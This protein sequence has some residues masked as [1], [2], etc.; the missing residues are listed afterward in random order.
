MTK[1]RVLERLQTLGD[2][3][4]DNYDSLTVLRARKLDELIES[5]FETVCR[6]KNKA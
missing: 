4:D 3:I 5:C 1:Q 2:V 6:R